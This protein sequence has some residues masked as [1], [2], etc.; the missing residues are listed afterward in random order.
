ME[1]EAPLQLSEGETGS[2]Q[3]KAE[4]QE[5]AGVGATEWLAR[6]GGWEIKCQFSFVRQSFIR[7]SLPADH[8]SLSLFQPAL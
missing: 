8:V 6:K 3:G 4:N 5:D 1:T 7:T 2:G